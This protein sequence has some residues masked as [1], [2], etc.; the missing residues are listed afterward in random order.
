M[1]ILGLNIKFFLY[2]CK[3]IEMNI[4]SLKTR[5]IFFTSYL[6]RKVRRFKTSV[7]FFRRRYVRCTGPLKHELNSCLAVCTDHKYVLNPLDIHRVKSRKCK[8]SWKLQ[9]VYR[10]GRCAAAAN[11]KWQVIPE[12]PAR[13]SSPPG[14]PQEAVSL[15]GD[16]SLTL[17]AYVFW[18]SWELC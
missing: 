16:A 8:I 9:Q 13:T 1:K 14:V 10:S 3:F 17:E 4:L 18:R 7:S 2:F 6:Q 12:A 15:A 5:S 11:N